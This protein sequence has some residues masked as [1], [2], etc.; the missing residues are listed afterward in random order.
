MIVLDLKQTL[1]GIRMRVSMQWR[2]TDVICQI[3]THTDRLTQILF[4]VLT[5]WMMQSHEMVTLQLDISHNVL[6]QF[7]TATALSL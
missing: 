5:L 4:N 1:E 2:F 7:S 6:L 3:N